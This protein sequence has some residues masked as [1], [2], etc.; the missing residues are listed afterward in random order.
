M[1]RLTAWSASFIDT[2]LGSLIFTLA[3]TAILCGIALAVIWILTHLGS[4]LALFALA[5][6]TRFPKTTRRFL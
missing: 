4:V 6:T 5:G 1:D 2:F 3:I